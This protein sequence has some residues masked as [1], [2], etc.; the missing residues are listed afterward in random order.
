MPFEAPAE[1]ESA[2]L[3]VVPR[4]RS[5]DMYVILDRSGSMAAEAMA[6]KND[7]ATVVN[8]LTC[9][10]A[11]GGDPA[12]CIPDLW[13]GAGTVSYQGSG[14]E[15]FR[16]W[17]DVQSNPSFVGVPTSDPGGSNTLEPLTFSVF[18]T[19][20]GGGGASFAMPLVWPRTSCAGSPAAL[21]GYATFGYPC[22]RQ[23][24]LPVV[25]LVTDEPPMNPSGNTYKQPFWD[26]VRPQ[27]VFRGAKLIGVLGS[28]PTAGTQTDLQ[29][30]ATQTGAVDAANGNAPLVFDG[31]GANAAQAIQQG[32]Q[33][34]ATRLP[35]YLR[36]VVQDDPT[37]SVDVVAAFVERVETMQLGTAKCAS[38]LS[39]QDSDGDAFP[40]AYLGVQAGTPVCWRLLPR[41]NT[42]VP[43][44]GVWQSFHATIRIIAEA[45]TELATRDAYF[46]VPPE[47]SPAAM[48]PGSYPRPH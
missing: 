26:E 19:I 8:N 2:D 28:G 11:G 18:A 38:G 9:P 21:A 20:T 41:M 48:R 34:L 25:L 30:M 14:A 37:D 35:L 22:F 13:A 32:L 40:D 46:L 3:S 42:T 4:L 24:S 39:E 47:R 16:N 29:T 7:L 44:T 27:M 43:S 33:T 10:P 23:G 15:A 36:A 5:L 12:T 45:E 1:P 6:V 17:V 31:S